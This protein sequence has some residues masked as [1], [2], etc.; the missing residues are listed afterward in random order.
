MRVIT[1]GR[2]QAGDP[3]VKTTTGPGALSVADTDA[4]LYLPDR[5]RA[6]AAGRPADPCPQPGLA[7]LVPRPAG[8][9]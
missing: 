8:G 1:E 3:I 5:D 4:L 2:I 9:G 6:E 7:G